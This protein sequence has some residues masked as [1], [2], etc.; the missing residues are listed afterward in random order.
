MGLSYTKTHGSPLLPRNWM[1]S[2]ESMTGSAHSKRSESMSCSY[3]ILYYRII[4]IVFLSLINPVLDV[5]VSTFQGRSVINDFNLFAEELTDLFYDV[6]N[7][8]GGE[9]AT[10]TPQL[11]RLDPNKFGLS[12]C[13]VDGQRLSIGDHDDKVAIQQVV[14]PLMYAIALTD[15]GE[16]LVHS[17]IG[18][19]PSGFGYDKLMLNHRGN[20][21]ALT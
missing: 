4:R 1:L 6:K 19:E 2:L 13:S 16:D 5:I 15:L 12:I 21:A 3:C 18:H 20:W 11:A 10:H 7:I 9:N 14:N 8:R 17:F